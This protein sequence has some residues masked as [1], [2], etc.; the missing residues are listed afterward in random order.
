MV[1]RIIKSLKK[2]LHKKKILNY[3]VNNY[4]I[5]LIYWMVILEWLDIMLLADLHI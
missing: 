4:I 1:D 3:F 5:I 2:I